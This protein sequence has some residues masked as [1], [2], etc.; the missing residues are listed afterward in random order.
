MASGA[1]QKTV[2][3]AVYGAFV[4][5]IAL[6]TFSNI[7]QVAH[8]VFGEGSAESRPSV[9]VGAAC[10]EALGAE[11]ADIERARLLAST[12]RT[13]DSAR[14]RYARERTHKTLLGSAGCEAD[15]GGLEALAALARLDRAAEAHAVRE[16]TELSPVRLAAQSF[17]RGPNP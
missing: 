8:R 3:R 13:G 9:A 4:V 7:W 6:F 14:S 15:P 17:I 1:R 5:V 16:S 12:E 2:G 10:G 11:I